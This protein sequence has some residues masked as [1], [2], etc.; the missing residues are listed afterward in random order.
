MKKYIVIA[1]IAILCFSVSCGKT[2]TAQTTP[3]WG[4]QE[5]NQ[6]YT[7]ADIGD[8]VDS[9]LELTVKIKVP[10][11]KNAQGVEA[12]TSMN[13]EFAL[14]GQS[15]LDK[16]VEW[17]GVPGLE[18]SVP[19]TVEADYKVMRA[20]EKFVSIRYEY[21]RYLGGAYPV[22]SLWGSTYQAET[23]NPV[24]L[25][26][27]FTVKEDVFVPILMDKIEAIAEIPVNRA[28][29]EGYFDF[30]FFYLTDDALVIYYQE[31]QLGPHAVG[32][33]EFEIPFEE[34]SDILAL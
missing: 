19:Y 10:L 30:N 18:P 21:Y 28:D 34:L 12:W 9:N 22:M 2:E 24:Y 11:I 3:E 26:D 32:T 8:V 29:L 1:L 14:Q 27:L 7:G 33:P 23:G 4:N 20:D 5:F 17:L 31:D 13:E 25:S 6:I 15:W 16:A